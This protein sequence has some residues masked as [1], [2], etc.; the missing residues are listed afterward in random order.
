MPDPTSRAPNDG[1]AP[2]LL[3][4]GDDLHTAASGSGAAPSSADEPAEPEDS[5]AA[6][7]ARARQCSDAGEARE[8]IAIYR[9]LLAREPRHVR[10]RNN[11]ALLLEKSGDVD[12]ALSELGKALGFDADNV[13]VL[14]NRAAILPARLKYAPAATELTRGARNG[15]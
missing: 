14:C 11:L 10:A 9:A 8:A 7:Y 2:E 15:E 5:T 6:M 4:F 1:D 12:G 3:P 13:S